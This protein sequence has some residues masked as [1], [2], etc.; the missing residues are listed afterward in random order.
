MT[1]GGTTFTQ[2]ERFSGALAW[3]MGEGVV[4]RQVGMR[5]K[6]RRGWEG[7]NREFKGVCEGEGGGVAGGM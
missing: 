6:T 7:F 5:E 3:V 4:G 2:E 1:Q